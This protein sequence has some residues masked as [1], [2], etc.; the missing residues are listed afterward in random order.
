V[1]IGRA[2]TFLKRSL[3]SRVTSSQLIR[4]AVRSASSAE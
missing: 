1:L 4:R 3:T 2:G